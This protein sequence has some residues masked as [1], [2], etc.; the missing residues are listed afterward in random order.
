ME[1]AP[2]E[3][4]KLEAKIPDKPITF[5]VRPYHWEWENDAVETGKTQVR[6]WALNEKNEPCLLRFDDYAIPC[7]V[8]LSRKAGYYDI[9]WDDEK[10]MAFHETICERLADYK[11]VPFRRRAHLKNLKPLY[12][13]QV[14]D[15]EDA[16]GEELLEM[17]KNEEIG[18]DPVLV[19]YFASQKGVEALKRMLK[20]PV[21]VNTASRN[22]ETRGTVVMSDFNAVDKLLTQVGLAQ[23]HLP[24]KRALGHCQWFDFECQPLAE[25][26]RMSK[27]K[28]E[29]KVKLSS[30][31]VLPEEEAKHLSTLAKVFSFDIECNTPN[32]NKFPNLW[33]PRC[34]IEA[35]SCALAFTDGSQPRSWSLVT[36]DCPP[37]RNPNNKIICCKDEIDLIMKLCLLIEKYDPEVLTG[38]NLAFD[39]EYMHARLSARLISWPQIGRLKDRDVDV[40]VETWDSSAYR[41]MKIAHFLGVNGR[42]VQDVYLE[43]YRNN[44]F[45]QY[46]LNYVANY[47]L[48]AGKV[49][50]SYKDMFRLLDVHNAGMK[51][52]PGTEKY[53]DYIQTGFYHHVNKLYDTVCKRAKDYQSVVYDAEKVLAT[54]DLLMA[55]PEVNEL[56]KEGL[57]AIQKVVDYCDED[58]NLCVKLYPKLKMWINSI[59]CS[60]IMCVNIYDLNTR[61]QQAR[62][63]QM[64]YREAIADGYYLNH[65]PAEKIPYEGGKVQ[66]N[67]AG[68]HDEVQT[69]DF[70][71]LYPSIMQAHNVCYTT[72]VPEALYKRLPKDACH[73][74]TVNCTS[75]VDPDAGSDDEDEMDRPRRITGAKNGVYEFRWLKAEYREG[76][77]PRMAKRLCVK[78]KEVQAEMK[79]C[80]DEGYKEVLDKRQNAYKVATNSIYGFTGANKLP[81]RQA[82]VAVTAWGR[83]YITQT[84]EFLKE[85]WNAYQVYGDTDSLM[86]ITPDY[87]KNPSECDAVIKKICDEIT[88]LFPDAI[89][90]KPE[91][92]GRMFS[93]K[94]KKYIMWLYNQL[95]I[96]DYV[97]PVD[98]VASAVTKQI[99]YELCA[100]LGEETIPNAL[101][102]EIE[103]VTLE[104]VKT[105]SSHVRICDGLLAEKVNALASEHYQCSI[106][107]T[108]RHIDFH[109]MTYIKKS[110]RGILSARRDNCKWAS[111]TYD[112]LIDYI[113]AGASLYETLCFLRDRI[114]L[115]MEGGV[116]HQE[117][118]VNKS[119]NAAYKNDNASM[120]LFADNMRA[121]GKI[122]E[123]GERLYYLVIKGEDKDYLGNRM[124]LE[125]VY[126]QSLET[127]TPY[128]IDY[129]YY[130]D[131]TL[132]KQADDLMFIAFER[133]LLALK[134]KITF[135]YG[136]TEDSYIRIINPVGLMVKMLQCG[137]T[138][139]D[140]TQMLDQEMC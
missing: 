46:N 88:A 69:I 26:K 34:P 5:R 59:E 117:L 122:I 51:A 40:K 63:Y 42:I 101:Q 60:N 57:A 93:I 131:K 32:H 31:R 68:V 16:E 108:W 139:D 99:A 97:L 87:V 48:G 37:N 6:A 127:D 111:K 33:D 134:S 140:F 70:N 73:V 82:A 39:I 22:F 105:L 9:E 12:H 135:V 50:L 28:N 18:T 1:S 11:I 121:L 89:I 94:K 100:V 98:K 35:I 17:I 123:P 77:L 64:L 20:Y 104:Y 43:V 58:A 85:K 66:D 109:T 120:K 14:P 124:I 25:K 83:D 54:Y 19:F 90:M 81:L 49:P 7:H 30:V 126:L 27:L 92:C 79:S 72:T 96:Y 95:G 91:Y 56:Y 8:V 84:S 38:F 116:T 2:Q 65:K 110:I 23:R 47:Y 3:N 133:Q 118:M 4:N 78:R 62:C 53:S 113:M 10:A 21:R 36:G 115:I 74:R 112:L 75:E 13:I 129:L 136:R 103:E 67:E 52:G 107:L 55:D 114:A 130:V 125:D 76:L 61:G 102:G 41:N 138:L 29:Y 132:R 106:G 71:S 80:K 24:E 45:P 15:Y 119:V 128:E 86:F 44:R 137:S